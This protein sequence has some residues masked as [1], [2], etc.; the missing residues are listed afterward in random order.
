MNG[1]CETILLDSL[2][3]VPTTTSEVY[4]NIAFHISINNILLFHYFNWNIQFPKYP[5]IELVLLEPS[6]LSPS[7][8][9]QEP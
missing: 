6:E 4:F 9:F 1:R 2:P 8:S 7:L 3:T 5:F